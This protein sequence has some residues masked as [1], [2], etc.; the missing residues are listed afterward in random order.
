MQSWSKFTELLFG[1]PLPTSA[2]SHERLTKL[3][4]LAILSSDALSSVAYATEAILGVL[5][6]AGSA[7]LTHSIPVS[8]S[9]G[10]LLTILILSYRQTIKAYPFGGGA[11]TVAKEN[12]GTYPGLV[13]AGSLLIDYILTVTVSIA[14]GLDALASA[15]NFLQPYKVGLGLICIALLTIAN[16]RGVKE[17]GKI[18]MVPTYAFIF[19]IFA[20]LIAGFIK[21]GTGEITPQLH[22]LTSHKALD[23]FLLLRAFSAGCTALTGVE[24]ISNGVMLFKK[25]EWKNART[26]LIY[27]GII[28]GIMFLG[29]TRL[30]SSYN[31]IPDPTGADTILSQLGRAVFGIG[32][33]YYILQF[34][35]LLILI[36]AANTSYADFPRLSSLVAKDGYLPRQLSHLGDRLVFS[37]GIQ[38][39]SI[40]AATLLIVFKGEVGAL[41]PLYSVGVFASFTLSQAGMVVHWFKEKGNGWIGSSLF[42]AIGAITTFVVLAIIVHTKFQEGAWLVVVS[43]PILV[44]FFVRIHR[45]YIEIAQLL[46]LKSIEPIIH[47]KR[48]PIEGAHNVAIILVGQIN[49][50]TIEAM[51]YAFTIADEVKA[52]HVDI[53]SSNLERIN[54]DWAK[55]QTDVPLEIIDSPY[56][57]VV[58]PLSQFIDK[59]EKDHTGH[60]TTVILP[61]FVTRSWWEAALHNQTALFLRVA[62]R[63]KERRVVS[64][65]RYYL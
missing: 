29:I 30:A 4:A 10:L 35:T 21:Q 55:L 19:S 53:G 54:N 49:K 41:L 63:T 65:F 31:F 52:V 2:Q 59:W 61:V 51:K 6:L 25:P 13:A 57:S 16:L 23:W 42:N 56:R 18:F 48:E 37:N 3:A 11:Y 12:L 34:A 7:A 62:L 15:F 32:P 50:G 1:K 8:I 20:L 17:A 9:I 24:A 27:M 28:L 22:T 64:T 43:I 33:L 5:V 14:A 47:A 58:K 45:H 46:R 40:L 36:L 44:F 39:L 38:I 60:Y 26:T